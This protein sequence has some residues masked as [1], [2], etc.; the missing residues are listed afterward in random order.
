MGETDALNPEPRINSDTTPF[1]GNVVNKTEAASAEESLRMPS[2]LTDSPNPTNIRSETT[3][4]SVLLQVSPPLT[5]M[6][7]KQNKKEAERMQRELEKQRRAA[8]EKKSREQATAVMQKR[9]RMSTKEL[10]GLEWRGG[11]SGY[12]YSQWPQN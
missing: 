8:A 7:V 2:P 11:S 4:S 12:T 6:D 1:P 3:H 5:G 10:D 9:S